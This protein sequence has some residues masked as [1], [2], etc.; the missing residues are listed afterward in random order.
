[1]SQSGED[2]YESS[3]DTS[4]NPVSSL[5]LHSQWEK[6]KKERGGVLLQCWG[7]LPV[8]CFF[9]TQTFS[10]LLDLLIK[11]IISQ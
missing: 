8:E 3:T 1:M 5:I 9:I 10:W 2:A 4:G 7:G 6:V 11:E